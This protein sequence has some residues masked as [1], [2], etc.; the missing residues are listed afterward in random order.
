MVRRT[1]K[2]GQDPTSKMVFPANRAGRVLVPLAVES[3]Q[4]LALVGTGSSSQPKATTPYS[5]V[6][7]TPASSS[8]QPLGQFFWLKLTLYNVLNKFKGCPDIYVNLTH[9]SGQRSDS[10]LDCN[11]P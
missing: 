5:A 10:S 4:K 11:E 6:F 1:K 3:L 8:H 9:H 2:A 7:C